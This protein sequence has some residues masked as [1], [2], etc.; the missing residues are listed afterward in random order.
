[1]NKIIYYND[2]F[3]WGGNFF[4][5]TH[6]RRSK[7]WCDDI[8]TLLISFN[9]VTWF[10][11]CHIFPYYLYLSKDTAGT[12]ASLFNIQLCISTNRNRVKS[13]VY[14]YC[15]SHSNLHVMNCTCCMPQLITIC[16]HFVMIFCGVQ[17][18]QFNVFLPLY[19]QCLIKPLNIKI[20]IV[21]KKKILFTTFLHKNF[22]SFIVKNYIIQNI[23]NT[24][25]YAIVTHAWLEYYQKL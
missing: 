3:T 1:M 22:E 11:A 15:R 2:Y 12:V 17:Q 21:E 23:E 4:S 7:E 10:I 19:Y 5:K 16:F 18:Q 8:K 25:L 20:F 9:D 24:F 14:S 13:T 6:G